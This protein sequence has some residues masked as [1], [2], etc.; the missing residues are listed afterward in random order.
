VPGSAPT[1]ADF[2]VTAPVRLGAGDPLAVGAGTVVSADPAGEPE[3]NDDPVE[4]LPEPES[5][6]V[7]TVAPAAMAVAAEPA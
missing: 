6:L 1:F 3:A 2:G 4:T 5:E 7:V